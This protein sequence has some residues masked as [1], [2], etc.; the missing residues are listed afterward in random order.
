M[1]VLIV[2]LFIPLCAEAMPQQYLVATGQG[3]AVPNVSS[4]I[5]LGR[6]F[7]AVENPAGVMYQGGF[8]GSAEAIKDGTTNTGFE[9]G[10]SGRSYGI[11]AGNLS[12]GN[13]NQVAGDL[14]AAF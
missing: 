9:A 13:G 4:L 11:A 6:G 3:I 2:G 1:R 5:N 10:Y 8:R 7:L 14:G 12:T